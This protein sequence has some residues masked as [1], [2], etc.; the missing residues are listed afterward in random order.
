MDQDQIKIKIEDFR[1]NLEYHNHRYYV[2]DDPDISDAEY[3]KLMRELTALETTYPEF[4]DSNSPT[5]R[6]GSLQSQR[7]G[8]KKVK[9]SLPMLSLNNAY[10][11]EDIADF[12]K[13]VRDFFI[14]FKNNPSL[15]IEF[16]VEPRIE[17]VVQSNTKITN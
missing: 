1:K 3:D 9:H 13:S 10:T 15:P 7:T 11:N 5:Q 16:I 8:F 6:V 17:F 14:E 4:F 2:L 12:I